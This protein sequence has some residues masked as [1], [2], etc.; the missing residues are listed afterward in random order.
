[1][2]KFGLDNLITFHEAGFEITDGYH[3]NQGRNNKTDNIIKDL[4]GLRFN[5][6]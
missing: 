5:L 6:K 1:M 4:Y 2:T 3:W